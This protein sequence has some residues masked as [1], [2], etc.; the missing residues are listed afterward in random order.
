M[1]TYKQPCIHCGTF[2]ER[3]S[4]FCPKCGSNSPF[5]YSCPSCGQSIEKEQKRC[6]SCGRDLYVTCPHCGELTFV[7][8]KCE[9]CGKSLMKICGNR[10]CRAE[11][12]FD[13]VKCTACGKSLIPETEKKGFFKRKKQDD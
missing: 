7:Q 11:Q 10:R 3:S 4:N 6:S 9:V 12:F 5:G 1:A 13:L 2:I 8:E